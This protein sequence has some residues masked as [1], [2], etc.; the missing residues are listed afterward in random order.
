MIGKSDMA[1]YL[2]AVQEG[3]LE[4]IAG[5]D[6]GAP[7]G[8]SP[9]DL[10]FLDPD[11]RLWSYPYALA[12]AGLLANSKKS[13]AI[14]SR[15][16]RSW[17]L[18]DSGGYQIGTGKLPELK[19]WSSENDDV[20]KIRRMWRNTRF[21]D[22]M[23]RW[24]DC[25]CNYAMTL[26]MPLWMHEG[27]NTSNPFYNFSP[28]ELLDVTLENLRFIEERRGVFGNCKFLNVMQGV[29]DEAEDA[30]YAKIKTFNFHGW[31]L[32]GTEGWNGGLA[33]VLRRFLILRDDGR[34]NAG[35][36]VVHLLG[37]SQ[38][39]WSAALTAV[40]RAVRATTNEDFQITFDSAT[41]FR[42]A[43]SYQSYFIPRVF[44]DRLSNWA[45]DIQKFPTTYRE[46]SASAEEPFC[47]GSPYSDAWFVNDVSIDLDPFK[48]NFLSKFGSHALA[49]H[50]VCVMAKDFAKCHAL[51]FTD[52]AAPTEILDSVDL[53]HR[54]FETEQWGDLLHKNRDLLEYVS[55]KSTW[56]RI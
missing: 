41:P 27:G 50:N 29:T 16:E 17:I 35:E 10:N 18:G 44:D 39:A 37:V 24:V 34:L 31:A 26:D 13:N 42:N 54:L 15:D 7:T 48:N 8:F 49:A 40:Q 20:A 53:I 55:N 2:P 3:F 1:M 56:T 22:D 21:I 46:V 4:Y 28:S 6:E 45:R 23:V 25:H 36:D 32:G 19:G 43:Y 47:I 52:G 30:W 9:K 33:R 5:E 12:S 51:T 14:T 11:N 38:Y